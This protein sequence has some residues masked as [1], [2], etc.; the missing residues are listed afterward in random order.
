MDEQTPSDWPGSPATIDGLRREI[1]ALDVQML[2]LLNRRAGLALEIGHLKSAQSGEN[3]PPRPIYVPERE[4]AVFMRL[5]ERNKG[6]LDDD[7][8]RSIYREVIS[9][10][11]ALEKP[12]RVAYFGPPATYTHMAAMRKFGGSTHFLPRRVISEVVHAVETGEADYGVVPVEN[13]TAGVV[14]STLDVFTTTDVKICSEVYVTIHHNLLSKAKALGKV[15]KVYS[16][17]QATAQCRQWLAI[18][19]PE[20]EIIEASS[21]AQ[22]ARQAA[23]DT[24][25]ATIAG[26][27]A[28]D[29]YGLNLLFENIEDNPRNRTRFLVVGMN[30]PARTGHDKTSLMLSVRHEAGALYKALSAFQKHGINLTMIES[31]PTRQTPWEYLFFMDVQGYATDPPLATALAELEAGS[32]FVRNLG[33]YPEAE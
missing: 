30:R 23:E 10:C 18:H 28:A 25:A 7:A 29:E 8:V 4:K 26:R 5:A 16:H 27:A 22:G 31:R 6:P 20:A 33:S 17:P 1:D 3:E 24:E 11:R 13:S 32:L 14:E 19:L 12:L 2:D 15:R 9:A 21:T